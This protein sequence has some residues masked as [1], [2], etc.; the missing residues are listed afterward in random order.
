MAERWKHC[1]AGADLR[2]SHAPPLVR[3]SQGHNARIDPLDIA[4]SIVGFISGVLS[5]VPGYRGERVKTSHPSLLKPP[6]MKS[7]GQEHGR[8]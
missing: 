8:T 7:A 1:P 6:S 3:T 5:H 4:P 2:K